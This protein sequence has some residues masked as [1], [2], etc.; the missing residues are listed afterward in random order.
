MAIHLIDITWGYQLSSMEEPQ[1]LE[2]SGMPFH[3][4]NH[5]SA[6]HLGGRMIGPFDLFRR[7]VEV[8]ICPTIASMTIREVISR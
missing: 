5:N 8:I 2:L 1:S 3:Q 4:G 7:S 6:V